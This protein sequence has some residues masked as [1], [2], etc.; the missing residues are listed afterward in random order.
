MRYTDAMPLAPS[1]AD[2]GCAVLVRTHTTQW[3][4]TCTEPPI[5]EARWFFPYPKPH[6]TTLRL[7]E[8]HRGALAW[9]DQY[10][11][12]RALAGVSVGPLYDASVE[13]ERRS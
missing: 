9:S 1:V 2:G 13:D 3:G 8:R 5:V 6:T 10:R 11:A 12:E 4:S 7:C